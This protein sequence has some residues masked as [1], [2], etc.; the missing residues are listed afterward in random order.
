MGRLVFYNIIFGL[1]VFLGSMFLIIPGV[2]AY[3]IFVFG[4]CYI[5]D[6]KLNIADAMTAS[7][8]ITKGKKARIISVLIGFFLLF[9]MP[10]I[11]LLS[12][13]GLGAA[14]VACFFT[15]ITSLILQRLIT[16]VYM[17]LEYKN[18]K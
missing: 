5:L 7:Y 10:I 14:F 18:G 6:L 11:L 9:K 17:D 8:E 4:Y 15:T 12:G 13:G 16:R 2:I 3:I 1:L